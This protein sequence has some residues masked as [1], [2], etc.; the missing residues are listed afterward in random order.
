M[1]SKKI[2]AMLLAMAFVG[3]ATAQTA[4]SSVSELL[5]RAK[6]Y[7]AETARTNKTREQEFLAKRSEQQRLL[8]E[9]QAQKAAEDRR[10]ERLKTLFEGNETAI[11]ELEQT[12]DVR[13]GNLG[14][15]KGVVRQMAGDTK[16][17]VEDSLVSLQ[18]PER[19]T[20][21]NELAKAE[22]LPSIAELDDLR[23]LLLEE[24]A[25]AGKVA[26]FT[27]KTF[28]ADGTEQQSE[29]IRVG[30]FNTVRGDEFLIVEDAKLKA[31]PTQPPSRFRSLAKGVAGA[32]SGIVP[33][34]IDPSRGQYLSQFVQK[35]SLTERVKQGGLVGYVIIS[36]GI[37]GLLIALERIF[38]LLGTGSKVRSQVKNSAPKSNNALGRILGVYHENRDIDTETLELK[39]DEAI[40]KETPAL[41]KRQTAIKIIAAVAPLLGLL[42][43]VTGMIETFQS[44]TL[45]GTGDPK[46]MA[47]G[48]SQALMT[49]VLGLVVAIPLVLLHSVVAGQS[50]GVIEVLEEQSAGLIAT[51]S[52]REL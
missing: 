37:F 50:K 26:R 18:Y 3:V 21:I 22:D 13:L 48:I 19:V 33:M 47:G 29:V 52:E 34:A 1:N 6:Q 31:L 5:Q 45:F 32:Q 35:P 17:T 15:L 11:V 20:M 42:G 23:I 49:T 46:L 12:R 41:E 51:H 25:E 10:S 2:I 24:M 28:D 27:T 36:L 39:L 30:V 9:A 38:Y 40:L 44:I 4:P 14:E 43:T 16:S 8:R 7:K